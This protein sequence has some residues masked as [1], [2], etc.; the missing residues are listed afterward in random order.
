MMRNL[1]LFV[2]AAVMIIGIQNAYSTHI[3]Q[4][5][6]TIDENFVYSV[7]D[8]LSITG[9][10]EYDDAA[11]SDVLL[12]VKISNPN[13]IVVSDFFLTSDSDGKFEFPFELT[14]NDASGDYLVNIMSMCREI[15]R[16]ICTHKTAETTISVIGEQS[17]IPDWVR[18]V[19]VWYAED[20]ISEKELLQALQFLIKEKIIQVDYISNT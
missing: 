7:G 2:I 8:N 10:V 19:F 4:P 1:L 15:H 14:E 9:W 17:K 13:G 11:T 20:S 16:D 12:S 3:S 18:N 6:L 5:I